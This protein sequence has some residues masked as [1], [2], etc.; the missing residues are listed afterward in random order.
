MESW[1]FLDSKI[2]RLGTDH[3]RFS[4]PRL[5]STVLKQAALCLG[6]RKRRIGINECDKALMYGVVESRAQV[7]ERGRGH[8]LELCRSLR[9]FCIEKLVV[10]GRPRFSSLLP[11]EVF[12]LFLRSHKFQGEENNN[13]KFWLRSIET[14]ETSKMTSLQSLIL[15]TLDSGCFISHVEEK[16]CIAVEQED[17]F[18]PTVVPTIQ[19]VCKSDK[20]IHHFLK[21][22]SELLPSMSNTNPYFRPNPYVRNPKHPCIQKF[23]FALRDDWYDPLRPS[24]RIGIAFHGTSKRN[25][26]YISLVGFDPRLRKRQP[27]GP[28]EYFTTDLRAALQYSM[29]NGDEMFNKKGKIEVIVCLV[30]LPWKKESSTNNSDPSSQKAAISVTKMVPN[31]KGMNSGVNDDYTIVISNNNHHL[32]IGTLSFSSDFVYRLEKSALEKRLQLPNAQ[33]KKQG[34][35]EIELQK[36][37]V[38][39]ED[40]KREQ[41]E[42]ELWRSYRKND[43]VRRRQLREERQEHISR[44]KLRHALR[45]NNTI[46]Q[47]KKLKEWK[48][49]LRK[50]REVIQVKLVEQ[51][52][53]L[54]K[55]ELEEKERDLDMKQQEFLKMKEAKERQASEMRQQQITAI[56]STTTNTIPN[57]STTTSSTGNDNNADGNFIFP[58]TNDELSDEERSL[59]DALVKNCIAAVKPVNETSIRWY[60]KFLSNPTLTFPSQTMANMYLLEMGCITD[61]IEKSNNIALKSIVGRYHKTA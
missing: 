1:W 53:L 2:G 50:E 28:G 36:K 38:F 37:Q 21:E 24:H 33:Q 42:A 10:A 60:A 20:F 61:A 23:K 9:G 54:L 58:I 27:H 40:R 8:Q 15:E 29:P 7:K 26:P 41:E 59:V 16:S 13:H 46:E 31:Q 3:P 22:H 17:I 34:E 56:L 6:R 43:Q 44:K 30:I 48:D 12:F 18:L 11:F 57:N 35:E 25:I 5:L 49:H 52:K 4:E 45:D 55:I 47:R 14:N 51:N 39:E 19:E 32:P